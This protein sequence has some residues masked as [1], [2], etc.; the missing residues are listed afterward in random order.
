MVP[1]IHAADHARALLFLLQDP[2]AVGAY[3]LVAPQTA[4][5]TEFMQAICKA[6]RRPFWLHLPAPALR[7]VLGEMAQLILAGRPSRPK[8]LLDAGFEFTYPTLESAL[9]EILHGSWR[10]V[11]R[12]GELPT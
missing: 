9:G 6:M 11:R 3:N 8:R 12:A 2:E 4:T 7:L 10:P 1:W 5:N